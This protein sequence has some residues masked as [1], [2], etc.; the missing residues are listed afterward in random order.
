MRLQEGVLVVWAGLAVGPVAVE[1][2]LVRVDEP[3]RL[4]KC[5]LVYRVRS[6]CTI[7]PAVD[8]GMP[9]LL[10]ISAT[11]SSGD[12]TATRF[13]GAAN[14]NPRAAGYEPVETFDGSQDQLETRQSQEYR[15]AKA[16]EPVELS[17]RPA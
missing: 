3:A 12:V 17:K 11:S 8:A 9:H 13:R 14:F 10:F 4:C 16:D 2:V 7:L 6:H 1:H 15:R 5:M